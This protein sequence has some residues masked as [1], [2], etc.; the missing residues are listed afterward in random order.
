MLGNKSQ[1]SDTWRL[2]QASRK[3]LSREESG[4]VSQLMIEISVGRIEYH[5]HNSFR[6]RENF[7]NAPSSFE[8][9]FFV[10]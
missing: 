4:A 1:N 10:I 6:Y 2:E 3:F 8:Y 9:N 7:I 5:E